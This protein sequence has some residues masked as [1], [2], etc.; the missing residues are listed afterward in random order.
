V[1]ESAI[2]RLHSYPK[3]FNMGHPAI[4]SLFDGAVVVQEKIDGSQFTFGVIGGELHCR[5]KGAV[6]H[7]ETTDNNFRAAVETAKRLHAK[8][9]LVEGW[10][11]RG[12]AMRNQKHNTVLYERAPSGNVILFDVDTGL[13]NRISDPEELRSVADALGLECVPTFFHGVVSSIDDLKRLLETP[14]CLGGTM[15]GVVAKNYSRWGKD[16]KMLMGKVVSEDF[17]E[18]HAHDWR[19]RNPTRTD[20]VEAVVACYKTDRR[21]EKAVER[22]RDAG[23]L[24]HSPRDIGPLMKEIPADIRAECEHEIKEALFKHFWPQI[25][26]GVRHGFP[27]WYKQR[28][29]AA[30]FAPADAA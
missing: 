15:E 19:K 18:A 12:E 10:Q 11:Y 29:L 2:D 3:V 25:E 21:W 14:S 30:Q 13:E 5:S 16:G 1:T 4:A 9:L 28:L 20:V 24:E 8:G 6:I 7:V 27:E 26:R 23:K 22:M 17:R